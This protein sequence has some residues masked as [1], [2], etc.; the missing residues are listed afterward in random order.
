MKCCP[1]FH[2]VQAIAVDALFLYKNLFYRNVEPKNWHAKNKNIRMAE[3][4]LKLYF[5]IFFLSE[6]HVYCIER[7]SL[8]SS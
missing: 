7:N 1:A 8:R 4:Y 3:I 6:T 2:Y 5:S